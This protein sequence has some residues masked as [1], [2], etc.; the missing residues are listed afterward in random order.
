VKSEDYY[1]Q[2]TAQKLFTD[3]Y[4]KCFV[5][6][7]YPQFLSWNNYDPILSDVN[8]RKALG[9]A[10]DVDDWIKTKYLGLA[11]RITGTSHFLGPAYNRDVTPLAYDPEKAT[12]LLEDAGWY[13]H[14]GDNIAD[15]D[16]KPLE[17]GFLMPAGNKASEA[18]GQRLQAAYEKIGVRVKMEPL[19][20]ATFQDRRK[21]REFSSASLAWVSST[22]EDDPYQIWHGSQSGKDMISS[23]D[24]GFH[25]AAC[26]KLIEAGRRELDPGKRVALFQELQAKIYEQQPYMFMLNAPT[27]LAINRK[28]HGVKL[29]K[30]FPAVRLRDMYYEEGTPG[31]RPLNPN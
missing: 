16:G 6:N 8:V 19:E 9:M 26:D 20:W 29:Y 21:H 2:A 3:R 12:Q 30:L 23:N 5:Y 4:Y 7:G 18:F 31:T 11:V 27:K 17:I 14:D 22:F 15:K 13:D 25:D 24:S 10:F 28:I 1:G